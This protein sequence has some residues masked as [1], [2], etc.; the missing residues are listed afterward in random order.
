MFIIRTMCIEL[1]PKSVESFVNSTQK[2]WYSCFAHRVLFS[3]GLIHFK[4]SRVP[5]THSRYGSAVPERKIWVVVVNCRLSLVFCGAIFL[6]RYQFADSLYLYYKDTKSSLAYKRATNVSYQS[7]HFRQQDHDDH[8]HQCW[9]TRE[10]DS[11][12]ITNDDAKQKTQISS[13]RF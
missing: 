8:C 4:I 6:Y 2:K 1:L 5:V 7:F 9:E 11:N 10:A 13:R 3:R 12:N